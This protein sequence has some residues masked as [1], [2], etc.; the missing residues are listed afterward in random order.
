M[1]RARLNLRRHA[2]GG[3][4]RLKNRGVWRGG[5]RLLQ[6]DCVDLWWGTT[7][8]RFS[9]AA[10][11]AAS[12]ALLLALG[13]T[14]GPIRA[15]DL[16]LKAPPAP[17]PIMPWTGFYAGGQIGGG[18]A[19]R[20]VSYTPNDPLAAVLIAG[21]GGVLGEQPIFPNSF[22]MSGPTGGV[23]AGYNWQF[24]RAWLV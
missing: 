3:S 15:A 22:S 4:E 10:A 17:A 1:A 20:D 8:R 19:T 13:W 14:A 16:P 6:A 7:M 12:A 18:W 24:N 21:T 2:A 5:N 11:A 9:L 23:A